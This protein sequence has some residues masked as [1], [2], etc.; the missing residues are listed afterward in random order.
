[1]SELTQETQKYISETDLKHRKK[2]GQY[3]TPKSI[4][5]AL[6][7]SLPKRKNPRVLEP[8]CGTGEF[9]QSIYEYFDNPTVDGYDVDSKLVKLS[10]K[11]FPE[12]NIKKADTLTLT[13]APMYDFVIG[14]PPYFEWNAPNNIRKKYSDVISGRVNIY[15]LFVKF[16][17]EMLVDGGYLAYVIPPSMNNGAY[18]SK[19]REYIISCSNIE[20]ITVLENEGSFENAQQKVMILVL[21]KCKNKGDYIFTKGDISIFSTNV[22]LLNAQFEGKKTLGELGFGVKT[23]GVVWNQQKDN[24]SNN[25]NDATLIWAH[26]IVEDEEGNCFI[27]LH[28]HKKKS[29]FIEIK[30]VKKSKK[31]NNERRLIETE[32]A[33]VVNRITGSSQSA[34]I[35]A[36]VVREKRWAAENHVNV[37]FRKN[38][39]SKD[40]N[41]N[42]VVKQ[43]TSQQSL[44]VIRSITGNTQISSKELA[45]LVPLDLSGKKV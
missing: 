6:M 33:I 18:F 31:K 26:N 38:D 29:Q 32:E 30:E 14:N 41:L 45:N 5:D 44:D 24:L 4:R 12:A 35:R 20:N 16:G 10:T 36:A 27:D 43:L 21:K 23:G 8:A 9:I 25:K 1:M 28:N 34:K 17:L 7:N 3:F 37:V 39:D 22:E 11:L 13:P 19:L 15:G 42:D 40:I 2:L